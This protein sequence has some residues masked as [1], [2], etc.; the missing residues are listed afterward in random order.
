MPIFGS[1]SGSSRVTMKI[2]ELCLSNGIGGLELYVVKSCI[3]LSEIDEV[4]AVVSGDGIIKKKIDS[5]PIKIHTLKPKFRKLPLLSANRLAKI[6]DQESIDIIHMHWNKD[7]PLAAF[8][9]HLSRR[10][11]SL[12]VSRHMQMTRS[13][14]DIYHRFLYGQM[15]R[16]LN[17]TKELSRIATKNLPPEDAHKSDYLYLGVKEPK[18]L[19]SKSELHTRRAELGINPDKFVVGTIGRLEPYKGQHLLI[20][21][22]SQLKKRG[23]PIQLLLIGHAMDDDYLI[24]LKQKVKENGMADDVIFHDFVDNPQEWMQLCSALALT[25]IEET[26][27]LVL[28]EAMRAG[29]AVVGSNRG[30]VLEIIKPEET[31]LL[32]DSGSANSLAKQLQHLMDDR[33]LRDR[34]AEDGKQFADHEFDEGEHFIKLR[35]QFNEI[36]SR[37]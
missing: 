17:V 30:G 11:P 24:S 10:K 28:I 4:I 33:L 26:F 2:L 18:H 25:T 29:V 5:L 32:F 23:Y 37:A 14:Q 1:E 21:A 27:G 31:G 19:L 35:K 34:L 13:K 15:D 7:L 12:V 6:I 20:D 16:M 3:S 9:K 36:L 8:A 22:A